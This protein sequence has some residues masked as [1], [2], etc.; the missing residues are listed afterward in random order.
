MQY[1]IV[2]SVAPHVTE[3]QVPNVSKLIAGAAIGLVG[4]S[5]I[6]LGAA[7]VVPGLP[8]LTAYGFGL[9]FLSGALLA[10]TR[11]RDAPR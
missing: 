1:S 2:P 8:A 4:A 10:I 3:L 9:T 6:A 5:L 7:G 11:L